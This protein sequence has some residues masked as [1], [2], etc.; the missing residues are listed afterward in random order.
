M[1]LASTLC[2]LL[3]KAAQTGHTQP[4]RLPHGLQVRVAA[5]PARLCVW[6]EAGVWTPGEAAER[7]GHTCA[8]ALGWSDYLLS[9]QGR[10][11]IVTQVE[12][13]LEAQA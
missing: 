12:P 9:W 1:T 10:Y 5:R 11:L 6:R 13:L 2:G 4:W 7:E 8:G 3:T